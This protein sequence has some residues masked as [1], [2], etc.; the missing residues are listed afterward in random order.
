MT[1]Y[2]PDEIVATDIGHRL[3]ADL[4]GDNSFPTHGKDCHEADS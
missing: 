3:A 2:L 4:R 1:G